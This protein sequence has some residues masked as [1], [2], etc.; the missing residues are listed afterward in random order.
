MD[1]QN[2]IEKLL[3]LLLLQQLKSQQDKILALNLAGFTNTEIADL[4]QTTSA[5]VSQSLYL[6]RSKP[7][8]RKKKSKPR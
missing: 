5:S 4:L 1:K 6:S 7:V 2:R 8:A 3:A